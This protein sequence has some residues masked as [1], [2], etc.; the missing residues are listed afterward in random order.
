MNFEKLA[1]QLGG[2]EDMNLIW[3]EP[4]TVQNV[5]HSNYYVGDPMPNANYFNT[6]NWTVSYPSAREQVQ[7]EILT[8]VAEA[9]ESDDLKKAKELLELAK[10]LKEL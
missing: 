8:K 10:A 5:V 4:S 7:E 3:E 1:N 9:I 6:S 2:V